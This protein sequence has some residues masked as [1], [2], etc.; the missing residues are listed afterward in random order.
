MACR[1]PF[2]TPPSCLQRCLL[3]LIVSHCFLL[4]LTVLMILVS[5]SQG[6]CR[7]STADILG[8]VGNRDVEMD[9]QGFGISARLQTVTMTRHGGC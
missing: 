6:S 8:S 4:V 7:M 5:A 2:Y 1:D 9:D 3:P